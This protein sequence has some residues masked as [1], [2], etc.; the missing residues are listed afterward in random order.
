MENG[1]SNLIRREGVETLKSKGTET[2][3]NTERKKFR[4]LNEQHK[5]V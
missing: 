5:V 4:G 2:H 3:F 1:G